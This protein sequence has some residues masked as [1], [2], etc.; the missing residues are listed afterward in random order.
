LPDASV[1]EA[2]ER[3]RTAIK[4]SG[5]EFPVKRVTVNLAPADLKKEGP[6]F[7]LPIAVGI[8]TATGQL[9]PEKVEPYFFV[10]ELSLEGTV[11]RIPGVLPMACA[12]S[13][14]AGE[15]SFLVVPE[16]NGFEAALAGKAKIL[17][18]QNLRQLVEMLLGNIA[19]APVEVELDRFFAEKASEGPDF[20]EVKGQDGVKRALEVAAAGGH[21]ILLMGSPGSGKTMLARRLT[22]ILPKL[23]LEEALEISK[24]YSSSGLLNPTKPLITERPFRAPHH[25]ASSASLIGGGKIPRPGEVSLASGGIL[26]LDEL[27]EYRRDVLEALRQPLEDRVVTVSRVAAAI[28]YPA[29]FMLVAAMNPCPCGYYGDSEKECI[30]TPYQIQRYR[31]KISG[32]LLDRI[33]IQVEVPRLKYKD[34]ENGKTGDSS[35]RIKS[36]VEQARQIQRERLAK[37]GINCNAQ[38]TPKLLKQFCVMS[39]EARSLLR[40]AFQQLGLSMRAYDRLLKIARTIADLS[41]EAIINK[42]HIAEAIQYRILDRQV[43]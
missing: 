20:A 36:R 39:E 21:N 25:T 42:S 4:N 3:V 38:M 27:P 43:N 6:G 34:L 30:C 11:R 2:R 7:D 41:G 31:G 18:V 32:P 33:D 12:L 37:F 19:L 40:L 22:S 1:R 9:D 14:A 10:G 28:T 24:I 15:T 17:A 8:L 23:T 35:V 5:F 16:E 26:F 29:S 13:G